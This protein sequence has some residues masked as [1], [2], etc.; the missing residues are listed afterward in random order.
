MKNTEDAASLGAACLAGVATGIWESVPAAMEVIVKE[1]KI[2]KPNKKNKSV[3][4]DLYRRYREL[5][6]RLRTFHR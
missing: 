4:D 3:Y 2:Y 5:S 6:D 1:D